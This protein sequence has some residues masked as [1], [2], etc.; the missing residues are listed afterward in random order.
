MIN[1]LC[2]C[3]FVLPSFNNFVPDVSCC[4]VYATRCRVH[5]NISYHTNIHT[6]RNTDTH[7]TQ[8]EIAWHKFTNKY[9]LTTPS[10]C[11]QQLSVVYP[12]YITERIN[13]LYQK[14]IWHD[15]SVFPFFKN[16]NALSEV[17]H[18]LIRFRFN[19]TKSFLRNTKDADKAGVNEQ[20]TQTQ[21]HSNKLA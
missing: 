16:K 7:H 12:Q 18:L 15:R 2:D 14:S 10:M 21:K 20:S 1:L 4:V 19:K 9:I 5:T 17:T 11:S 3:G 13:H 8:R 6:N